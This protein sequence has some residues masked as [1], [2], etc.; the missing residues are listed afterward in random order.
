M[1]G[2]YLSFLCAIRGEQIRFGSVFTQKTNQNQ[3]LKNL[4]IQTGPEPEPVQT[5]RFRFGSV[6]FFYQ[7]NRKTCIIFLGLLG[8]FG[9]FNGLSDGFSDGLV[10]NVNII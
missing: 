7:K 6:R 8:F 1:I 9:L 5:D 3:I 4:K 10:I 2:K